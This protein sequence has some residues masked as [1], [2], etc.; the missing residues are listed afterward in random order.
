MD[1]EKINE[2]TS[3]WLD[4]DRNPETRNEIQHLWDE[5]EWQEL[6][7][8]LCNRI[9]FGTAGLRAKMQAGYSR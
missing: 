6:H 5:G 1:I 9:E 7:N 2:L 8:R 3:Q 4:F